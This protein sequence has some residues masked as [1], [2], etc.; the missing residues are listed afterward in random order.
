MKWSL[1]ILPHPLLSQSISFSGIADLFEDMSIQITRQNPFFAD[2]I[3]NTDFNYPIKLPYSPQNDI[4]FRH[5]NDITNVISTSD[6]ASY[7]EMEQYY[8]N[9]HAILYYDNVII[10]QGI[11]KLEYAT[12]AFYSCTLFTGL[13]NQNI[14]PS[15]KLADAIDYS[16][17]T[18]PFS[19]AF[20]DDK[21]DNDTIQQHMTAMRTNTDWDTYGYVY[22]PMQCN[23][24]PD[25]TPIIHFTHNHCNC[26]YVDAINGV[27][28]YGWQ[29]GNP[30]FTEG[31]AQY[32]AVPSFFLWKVVK[33]MVA[34]FDYSY[35]GPDLS[36]FNNQLHVSIQYMLLHSMYT[37]THNRTFIGRASSAEGLVHLRDIDR[38]LMLPDAS[39][40]ELLLA[41]KFTLAIVPFF[42]ASNN[43]MKFVH[44]DQMIMG[45]TLPVDFTGKCVPRD[46]QIVCAFPPGILFQWQYDDG[47]LVN[48][49]TSKN[50]IDLYHFRGTFIDFASL[51]TTGNYV[52]SYALNEENNY[53]YKT[54]RNVTTGVYDAWEIYIYNDRNRQITSKAT[55]WD[56]H[57]HALQ[58]YV[59][60]I[61]NAPTSVDKWD[62]PFTERKLSSTNL[63]EWGINPFPIRLM[64]YYDNLAG[65]DGYAYTF[66]GE[67]Y[68]W[69][70]SISTNQYTGT[71]GHLDLNLN[72]DYSPIDTSLLNYIRTM[73]TGREYR[74]KLS[75]SIT[76]YMELK[77][78]VPILINGDRFIIKKITLSLP[79]KN[80]CDALLIKVE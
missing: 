19:S 12:E 28:A 5:Y 20:T 39:I 8:Y 9:R 55:T 27:F 33:D 52:N 41:L 59:G 2:D 4:L 40:D 17:Q 11:L 43:E 21:G 71:K 44:F 78:Y 36:S 69:A 25:G 38:N 66:A 7:A 76:D 67:I 60:P 64:M 80:Y 22:P 18:I 70:T 63:K 30:V 56:M 45:D 73:R 29:P 72:T 46:F 58:Q 16:V 37:H 6:A 47:D 14:S 26:N 23:L 68:P 34:A 54:I 49:E 3:L 79:E 1:H 61:L 48:E 74:V 75:L 65:Q 42:D 62:I 57:C 35:V 32:Y 10:A 50:N 15:T 77:L 13:Q 24:L 53:Y 51:P 31:R